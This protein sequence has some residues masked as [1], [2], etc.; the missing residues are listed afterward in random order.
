MVKEEMPPDYVNLVS[1]LTVCIR[2]LDGLGLKY[3]DPTN[4]SI[5]TAWDQSMVSTI[6]DKD[7]VLIDRGVNQY[8]GDGIYLLAW[9]GHLFIRR[10]Q[11]A[12]TD[13][14]ELVA[15]SPT[16]KDRVAQ[17][18]KVDVHAKALLVWKAG[19]L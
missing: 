7:L 2:Q 10:L 17:A 12:G 18:G 11:L 4:L 5:I 1:E 16:H 19:K 6:H 3:S 13:K 8:A 15:H 14:L 9:A